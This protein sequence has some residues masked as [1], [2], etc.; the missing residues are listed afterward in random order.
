MSVRAT[1]LLAILDTLRGRRH[2]T[3]AQSLAQTFEVSVRTIYR[4]I[5]SLR[6]QGADIEGE[7]GVG[8]Q[9]APGFLL[10]P[11]AFT[12]EEL[13]AVVLGIQW[14]ALQGDPE[15]SAAAK[16]SLSRIFDTLPPKMRLAVETCGLLVPR[17]SAPK[18]AL[19]LATLR[20]AI[21]QEHA[22][23]I[24]YLDL[25]DQPSKRKIWPFLLVFFQ[26]VRTVAAWCELR[27]D[28]RNFRADRIVSLRDTKQRYPQ[29]RHGLIARWRRRME[30][31]DAD[32]S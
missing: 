3:S 1:R 23:E 5:E 32:N 24:E 2:P 12:E 21:R 14:V 19:W 22:I 20:A 13:E 7:P 6:G 30:Q 8:Y 16:R 27:G 11:L 4:D 15:L 29:R 28:F 18:P 25:K 17:C 9:L 26:E 10:P 31:E